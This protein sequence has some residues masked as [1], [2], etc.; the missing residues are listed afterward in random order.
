MALKDSN[1]P[2][3]TLWKQGPVSFRGGLGEGGGK[4]NLLIESPLGASRDGN[5]NLQKYSP[6]CDF[7]EQTIFE[8]LVS[9]S[10]QHYLVERRRNF[11]AASVI[12]MN[13]VLTKFFEKETRIKQFGRTI[14]GDYSCHFQQ[15]N[16]EQSCCF[17]FGK[18]KAKLI[19]PLPC[20]H[21]YGYLVSMKD[22]ILHNYF[23]KCQKRLLYCFC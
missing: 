17:V 22:V 20:T 11:P 4:K 19:K 8:G 7:L 16:S 13:A 15:R 5:W 9:D 23:W 6:V 1:V 12:W 10:N 21:S 2:S 14:D 3:P 18:C